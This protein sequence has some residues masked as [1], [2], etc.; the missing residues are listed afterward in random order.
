MSR[1]QRNGK[2]PGKTRNLALVCGAALMLWSPAARAGG[3]CI[4]KIQAKCTGCHYPSR[5]CEQ[6][7]QKS[8]RGW[9]V[10]IKRMLRYGLELSRDKQ[11]EMLDC[12]QG[13]EKDRGNLCR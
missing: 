1:G 10:T 4:E 11:D 6:I 8:R 2:M 12:L 9:E 13:L 3:S 7:G 5:I